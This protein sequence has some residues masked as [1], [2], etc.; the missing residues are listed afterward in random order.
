MDDDFKTVA[1]K[2]AAELRQTHK[3]LPTEEIE[4]FWRGY[5]R[6]FQANDMGLLSRIRFQASQEEIGIDFDLL[7]QSFLKVSL[8]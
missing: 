3:E 7:R 8:Q 1:A 2:L 5:E 4:R 6:W